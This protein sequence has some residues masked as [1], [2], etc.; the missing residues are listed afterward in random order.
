[1]V[2]VAARSGG[3]ATQL[4]RYAVSV[5]D[6][7]ALDTWQQVG[8]YFSTITDIPACGYDPLRK[9]F[10]KRGT[11]IQ[12]FAYWNLNTP[13]PTNNDVTFT[14]LDPTGEFPALAPANALTLKNC[15]LDFDPA[16]KNFVLWCGDARVWTLTPPATL[17][18]SGWIIQRQIT[19]P[20]QAVPN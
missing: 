12:P 14:P 20:V 17:S 11:N 15:G 6:N 7:P 4:Y 13:G 16:R 19:S 3:T 5:V 8:R 18:P 1:M 10:V 9:I 2:Y